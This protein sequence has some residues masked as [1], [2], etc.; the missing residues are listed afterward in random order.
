MSKIWYGSFQNRIM[1]RAIDTQAVEPGNTMT[2][3]MY[4]DRCIWYVEA[5]K[6]DA[7]GRVKE[8]NL[9]RPKTYLKDFWGYDHEIQSYEDAKLDK[10]LIRKDDG[11][12]FDHPNQRMTI[13]RT[14]RGSFT[15][16]GTVDGT[17]F[18]LGDFGEYQDPS[19]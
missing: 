3:F 4:T 12:V 11:Y 18:R 19:F 16:S 17:V 10:P 9:V 8:I 15:D 5:V 1:E 13:Y 7:K 6:L 14:R 2:Q